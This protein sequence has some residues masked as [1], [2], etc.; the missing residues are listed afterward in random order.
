MNP[1]SPIGRHFLKRFSP[2]LRLYPEE[3]HWVGS[4]IPIPRFDAAQ[5]LALLEMTMPVFSQNPVA[6][7]DLPLDAWVIGD[8]H[9]NF[10]D[11]LRILARIGAHPKHPVVF[12][13]DYVDRGDYSVE[14]VLLLFTL[15]V[16]FPEEFFFIRGNHEFAKL[17]EEYGF[18]DEC[19]SRYPGSGIWERVN[20]IFAFHSSRL[21]DQVSIHLLFCFDLAHEL[22]KHR[23]N[24]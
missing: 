2:L 20:A 21:H 7:L 24:F 22:P 9:G 19:E 4:R 18:K 6:V 16:N 15:K 17:N 13:G 12:L 14:V 3:I 1:V 10:H 5:I 11:L 8:I 23:I